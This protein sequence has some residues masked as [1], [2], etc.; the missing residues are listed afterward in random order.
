MGFDAGVVEYYIDKYGEV[1][2]RFDVK[3]LK[4]WTKKKLNKPLLMEQT[5]RYER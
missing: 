5:R 3:S 4:E 1:P 2:M